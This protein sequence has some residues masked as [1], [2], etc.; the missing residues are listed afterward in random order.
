MK[1]RGGAGDTGRVH[2]LQGHRPV[3]GLGHYPKRIGK[4]SE[5]GFIQEHGRYKILV[6]VRSLWPCEG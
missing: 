2:T 5:R 3:K 6:L 4:P 1:A